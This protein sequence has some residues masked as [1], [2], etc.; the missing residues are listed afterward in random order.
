MFF[1]ISP[2]EIIVILIL[3]LIVLGPNK[4]PE[5]GRALGKAMREFRSVRDDLTRE[6]TVR[7]DEPPSRPHDGVAGQEGAGQNGEADGVDRV[8]VAYPSESVVTASAP[9]P[10]WEDFGGYANRTESTVSENGEEARSRPSQS[11]PEENEPGPV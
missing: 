3:A 7:L 4:F 2:T 11:A 8:D 6:L 9:E 10:V 5:A 1:G